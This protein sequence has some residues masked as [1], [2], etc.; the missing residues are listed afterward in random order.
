MLAIQII[1]QEE[2]SASQNY[3]LTSNCRRSSPNYHLASSA[4]RDVV[5]DLRKLSSDDDVIS[6]QK[7]RCYS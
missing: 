7:W 1:K 2:T 4:T 5:V 6:D 3:L